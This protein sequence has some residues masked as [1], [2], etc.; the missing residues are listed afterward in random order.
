MHPGVD[1]L[2]KCVHFFICDLKLK[3]YFHDIHQVTQVLVVLFIWK[4]I[5]EQKQG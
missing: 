1:F 5:V 4:L 3:A 2:I